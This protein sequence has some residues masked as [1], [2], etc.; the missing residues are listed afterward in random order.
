MLPY[1]PSLSVK[2]IGYDDGPLKDHYPINCVL[3]S[4]GTYE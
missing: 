3:V 2:T 1:P 4:S